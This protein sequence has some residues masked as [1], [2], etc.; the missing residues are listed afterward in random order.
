MQKWIL[1]VPQPLLVHGHRVD[2]PVFVEGDG[3]LAEQEFFGVIIWT[4]LSGKENNN[5]KS[6]VVAHKTVFHRYDL[7]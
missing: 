7:L 1:S 5:G 4:G 3:A 2:V 6:S